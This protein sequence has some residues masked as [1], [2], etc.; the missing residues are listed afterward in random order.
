MLRK[1]ILTVLLL[2]FA[3]PL[4]ACRY[5]VREIGFADFGVNSYQLCFLYNSNTPDDQIK[6]FRRVTYAALHDANVAVEL[7]NIEKDTNSIGFKYLKDH[8]VRQFPATLLIS[9]E[10]RALPFEFSE[11][12]E[13]KNQVWEQIETM[14]TSPL[15]A[16][17]LPQL[18]KTYGVVLLA[19]GTDAA[20]NRQVRNQIE[21]AIAEIHRTLGQL[22]KPVEKPPVLMTLPFNQRQS[23]QI[24]LWSLGLDSESPAP[25]VAVLY[26]RGRRVGPPLTGESL[27]ENNLLNLLGL[28]GADCECG[29]D[30]A[31][32]LGIMFPLRW[33]GELRDLLVDQL[34]FDV[35]NP[36]VKSEM[37]QILAISEASRPSSSSDRLFSYREGVIE[38]DTQAATP[39]VSVS[40]LQTLDADAGLETTQSPL[41]IVWIVLG[42]IFL[43][44]LV[45]GGVYLRAQKRR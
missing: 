41:K 37:S 23:E 11:S 22:P 4:Y 32:L 20:Q 15:R 10:G 30:R 26:G 36:A 42:A 3:H 14:V 21:K 27:N 19:E 44:V 8:P 33:P 39:R 31:W 12:A 1:L 35:E 38:T 13:F 29:L 45:A 7:V 17:L 24:L 5:T 6:T 40:G 9:P 18:A 43:V 25:Q 28:I 34:H 2:M 16:R